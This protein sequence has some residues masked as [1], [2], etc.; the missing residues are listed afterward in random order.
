MQKFYSKK[1]MLVFALPA[2]LVY[3]AFVVFP[4]IP[5]LFISFQD[6]NGASSGGWVFFENFEW[7][8]T[9]KRFWT[10]NINVWS[11]ALTSTFIGLPISLIFA[12]VLNA[13]TKGTRRFFKIV[14]FIPSILSVAVLAQMFTGVFNPQWGLLNTLLETIGFDHL[15]NDW[16]TDENTALAC[17]T[18]VF[19]WQYIGFNMV[20]FYA[21]LK[22]VPSSY[23]EAA[24]IDGAGPIRGAIYITIPLLQDVIKYVLLISVLGSMSLYVH[25]LMLTKGGPGDA[26]M[27]PIYFLYDNAFKGMDFG[28]GCAIAMLHLIQCV[29]I[30]FVINRFVARNKIEM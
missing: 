5:Q 9:N 2:L 7:V 29:V 23:Y 22:A 11:V 26:S 18:F 4:L 27:T 25:V 19:I 28:R 6:H 15:A 8:L 13:Q 21:G 3:T 16:L 30:S 10:T 12:L 1:A 24:L 14:S 17:V 20:L